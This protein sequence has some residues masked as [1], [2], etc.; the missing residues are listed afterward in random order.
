M[1]EETLKDGNCYAYRSGSEDKVRLGQVR[2]VLVEK[3]KGVVCVCVSECK[4]WTKKE[5][6]KDGKCYAYRSGR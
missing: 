6:L 5:R 4:I 1:N 3:E 2:W